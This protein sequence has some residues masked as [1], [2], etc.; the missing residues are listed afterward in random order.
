MMYMKHIQII[1]L[2]LFLVTCVLIKIS[3][4]RIS[5]GVL[6]RVIH[7]IGPTFFL[8]PLS[9]FILRD[10][11]STTDA[12]NDNDEYQRNGANTRSINI[13]RGQY[14]AADDNRLILDEALDDR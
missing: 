13:E 9:P 4:D 3:I 14:P 1:F 8:H 10:V 5:V 11:T 6:G 12:D 7:L 2:R